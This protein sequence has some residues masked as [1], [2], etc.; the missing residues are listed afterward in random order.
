M[1]H[2]QVNHRED[3]GGERLAAEAAPAGIGHEDYFDTEA[4]LDSPLVQEFTG[5]VAS[6]ISSPFVPLAPSGHI[7]ELP[8]SS[9]PQLAPSRPH[10]VELRQTLVP[11]QR[12]PRHWCVLWH[13]H[14][15]GVEFS[16]ALYTS[17][18]PGTSW[19]C[20]SFGTTSTNPP[21]LFGTDAVSVLDFR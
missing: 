8:G 5:A 11:V 17:T 18:S 12:V 20:L 3:L 6:T 9:A 14:C 4:V 19:E 15:L 2:L 16:T 10:T 7:T 13:H 1:L 21:F